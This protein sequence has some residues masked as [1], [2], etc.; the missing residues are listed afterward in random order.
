MSP[1]DDVKGPGCRWSLGLHCLHIQSTQAEQ[2]RVS[3]IAFMRSQIIRTA[4]PLRHR[5]LAQPT[6]PFRLYTTSS[7]P[8]PRLTPGAKALR[9]A[10]TIPFLGALFSSK[11]N[12]EESSANMSYPDQRSEDQWRAVLSPGSSS[13]DPSTLSYF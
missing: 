1:H 10:P 6:L 5:I 2:V 4:T 12:S 11:A 13:L 7:R 3:S 8:N 9:A